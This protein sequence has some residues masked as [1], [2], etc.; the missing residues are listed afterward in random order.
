MLLK[1]PRCGLILAGIVSGLLVGGRGS[2][3][4][5]DVRTRVDVLLTVLAHPEARGARLEQAVAAQKELTAIGGAAVPQLIQA[6]LEKPASA[7][8]NFTA[9]Q[10]LVD[11]GKPALPSIWAR[12]ADLNDE[13][14]WRLMPV[15]EKHDRESVRGY[16]LNCLDSQG[17]VRLE[18]WRFVLRTKELRAEERYF[19]AIEGDEA[20]GIRW[21]LLPGDKPIYEEKRENNVLIHLLEPDSWVAKGEGQPP[22]TGYPPPWW[23]DGRPH[24]IRT[25]HQ[26]RVERAAGVLLRVLEEKGPGAG[27]LAG[28]IIPALAD[29]GYKEAIPELERV[30]ASKPASGGLDQLHP[31]ALGYYKSVRQL[32]A[33]AVKRLR[34]AKP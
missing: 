10:I 11:I 13:R 21:H 34:D 26:R 27:H 7:N 18:A 19:K 24:V 8:V 30:A 31:H 23:P 22:P 20:P 17:P 14:R 1:L 2:T 4:E 15:F 25:L 32:A 5:N 9:G 16:A 12:W 28:Q 29:L 3:Q 6:V 33:D